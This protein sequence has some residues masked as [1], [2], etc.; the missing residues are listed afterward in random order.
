MKYAGFHKSGSTTGSAL[1]QAGS[2]FALLCYNVVP[3]LFKPAKE[4]EILA[5]PIHTLCY[6]RKHYKIDIHN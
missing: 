6:I 3:P 2:A 1:R 5:T 4:N